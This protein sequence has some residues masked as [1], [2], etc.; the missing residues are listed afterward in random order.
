MLQK[1]R[2]ILAFLLSPLLWLQGLS[3]AAPQSFVVG[4]QDFKE[5][6]PY[7]QYYKDEYTGFNRKLLDLFAKS[8]NY[9]FTYKGYPIKR[10]YRVFLEESVDFKYPDNPYWSSD[11]KK[12]KNITYSNPVV[13]Y[14]DG[15]VVKPENK[16]KDITLL[17]TLGIIRGFTPF[18]YLKLLQAKTIRTHEN[19]NYEGLLR[20]TLLGRVDGAY[21]NIAVS[22]YYLKKYFNNPDILIFDPNL[23]H[24]RSFRYL[25]S[26]RH[27]SIIQ[28]FNDFL[29]TNQ[30]VIKKLK[31]EYRVEEGVRE[32]S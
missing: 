24:S 2:I 7:S 23:P 22:R 20:Q 25:S 8:R 28:E 11:L 17:K 10:L 9:N 14:I 3:I 18:P 6:L 26:I 30:E 29:Q 15:V 5:Y 27:P 1:K 32:P 16:G 21:L 4:V 13:E 19:S 12:G 31:E